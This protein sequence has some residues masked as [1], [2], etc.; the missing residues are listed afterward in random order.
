MEI[1]IT[2]L[3]HFVKNAGDFFITNDLYATE[4]IGA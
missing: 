1:N 3:S 4:K 2:I